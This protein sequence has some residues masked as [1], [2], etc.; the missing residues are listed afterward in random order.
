MTTESTTQTVFIATVAD[1]HA[2]PNKYRVYED[3]DEAVEWLIG[4]GLD[5]DEL[6]EYTAPGGEHEAATIDRTTYN[7][8]EREVR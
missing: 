2:P 6:D 1:Q 3:R 4:E 5:P 8:R 7:I